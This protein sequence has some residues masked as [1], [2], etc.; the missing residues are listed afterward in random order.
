MLLTLCTACNPRARV[1]VAR[2]AAEDFH[3]LYNRGDYAAM[4]AH[5][6]P[7]VRSSTTEAAFTSY[8]KDV[9]AKLGA[10]KSADV[11][12]YN[13]TYVFSGPQVRLDYKCRFE[14]GDAFE[15]FEFAFDNGRAVFN[16]YR[17]DSPKLD[18]KPGR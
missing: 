16:G 4:Y 7:E 17:L 9:R 5:A 12:N 1:E 15:S 6:G 3:N 14:G 18:R 10:L 2:Y 13:L 11:S 8:E